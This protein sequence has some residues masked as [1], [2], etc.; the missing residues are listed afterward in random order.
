MGAVSSVT[1]YK[2]DRSGLARLFGDLE[3]G[4][5]EA[6]WELGEGTVGSVST[7]LDAHQQYTT[8]QTVLNRLVS[9]G[10]LER[11]GRVVGAVLYR[12]A[13]PRNVFLERTSRQVVESLIADFGQAALRGLVD[14][15]GEIDSGQLDALEEL[16]QARR[17]RV[18]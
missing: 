5:M 8:I 13:E 18:P 11:K 3:A 9:K 10:I 7:F 17:R 2:L 6:L 12:P 15:V 1:A 4:I 14:A 16:V